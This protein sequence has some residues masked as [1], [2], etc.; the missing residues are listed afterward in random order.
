[1]SY[2]TSKIENEIWLF[3]TFLVPTTEQKTSLE[4]LFIQ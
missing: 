3:L 1:M 2:L 4:K